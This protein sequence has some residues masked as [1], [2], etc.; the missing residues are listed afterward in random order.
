MRT[1]VQLTIMIYICWS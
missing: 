1:I